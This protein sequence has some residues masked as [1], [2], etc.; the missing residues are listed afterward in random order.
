MTKIL[1]FG[2]SPSNKYSGMI[3]LKIDWFDLLAVQGTFRSLLQYHKDKYL[4]TSLITLL[5]PHDQTSLP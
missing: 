1:D 3:S 2:I 5:A 4:L